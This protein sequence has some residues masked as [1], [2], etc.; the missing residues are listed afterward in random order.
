MAVA[1]LVSLLFETYE[2]LF[3]T[4]LHE[5]LSL[6]CCAH[7]CLLSVVVVIEARASLFIARPVT[8]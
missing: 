4:L 1:A 7:F 2:H 5:L 3:S 6:F 8:L